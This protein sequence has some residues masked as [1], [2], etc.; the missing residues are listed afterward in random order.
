MIPVSLRLRNFMCYREGLPPLEFGDLHV[1]C[2][3]GP[4]G[5]G[6]SA[7]LDAITWAL[8]G[9]ARARSDDALISSG[10][11][12]MEVEF[13]FLLE[14]NHHRVFRRRERAVKGSGKT[15][16]DLQ[17]YGPLGWRSMAGERIGQTEK[18][19]VELLRMDY[20][21]FINSA[22]LLQGRADEFTLKPP[23]ERKRVLAEILGLA[24]YDDL[25]QRARERFRAAERQ[26]QALVPLLEDMQQQLARREEHEEARRLAQEDV[27]RGER[28]VTSHQQELAGLQSRIAE[29]EAAAHEAEEARLRLA[30]IEKETISLEESLAQQEGRLAQWQA[31]LARAE[32]IEA[33]YARLLEL[34]ERSEALAQAAGRL[35]ALSERQRQLEQTIERARN[36]YVTQRE[37]LRRALAEGAARLKERPAIEE[38]LAEIRRELGVLRE[39]ESERA[40]LLEEAQETVAAQ[41]TLKAEC[42]RLLEEM[43]QLRDKVDMLGEHEPSAQRTVHCPLCQSRLDAKAYARIRQSYQAEGEQK[44]DQY[45]ASEKEIQRLDERL[46]ELQRRQEQLEQELKQVRPLERQQAALEKGQVE[47]AALAEQQATRESQ[48]EEVERVLAESAYAAEERA[49]LQAVLQEMA[50]LRYNREEHQALQ[51]EI[52]RSKALEEEHRLLQAA[53][54]RVPEEE[55]RLTEMRATHRRRREEAAQEQERLQ[56]L[57][58]RLGELEALRRRR[59]EVEAALQGAQETLGQARLSLGAAQR[60]LERLQELEATYAKRK[61]AHREALERRGIYEELGNALGK[62]GV[63]AML[64]ETA[65]PEIEREANELLGRMTDGTMALQLAMQRETKQGTAVETLDIHISDLQGTREYSLY[66]GGEAFRINFA[67]RIALSRLLARRAGASLQTLVI[68]EGFGTQDA[69]GRERLVEAIHSIEKEFARILVITHIQEMKELFPVRVEIEKTPAGSRWTVT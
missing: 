41:R 31:L 14:G 11:Q 42:R 15:Q 29:V 49:A 39:K 63:Q 4:N 60:E 19:I 7:L 62:R 69:A 50:V 57:Q 32:P 17:V 23:A 13:E 2:I 8:W 25:E 10:A 24:Y 65:V 52:A 22:F 53:R 35:L 45:R 40:T 21:T 3:S 30:R 18:R 12:E 51:Q 36:E 20:E 1:A 66:S 61:A 58:A 5:A 67:L 34:R 48:M 27:A 46:G 28:E 43:K 26:V 55:R 47:L 54:E 38:R 44:R 64:I 56:A 59:R 33:A 9:K 68:D 16:L 6:K 37:V